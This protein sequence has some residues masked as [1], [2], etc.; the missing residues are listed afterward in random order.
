MYC[1]FWYFKVGYSSPR[2]ELALVVPCSLV[3]PCYLFA[4]LRLLFRGLVL[5]AAAVAAATTAVITAV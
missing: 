3:V 5:P 1:V 2:L 4:T